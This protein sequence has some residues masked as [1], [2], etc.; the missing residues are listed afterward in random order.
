MLEHGSLLNRL[1]SP[2]DRRVF[3]TL[4]NFSTLAIRESWINLDR[5]TLAVFALDVLAGL[6]CVGRFQV[7][8]IPLQLFTHTVSH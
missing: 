3:K 7:L 6:R 1:G 4:T 5:P 8:C 2:S